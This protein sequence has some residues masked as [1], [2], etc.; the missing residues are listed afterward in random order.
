MRVLN[1]PSINSAL[2]R[3]I[4]RPIIGFLL[5]NQATYICQAATPQQIFKRDVIEDCNAAK[6]SL[7][8]MQETERIES[9]AYLTKVAG[10]RLKDESLRDQIA[11]L[12]IGSSGK[13]VVSG[14]NVGGSSI[15]AR[16]EIV[17]SL[18]PSR[19]ET[20]R[21][22][23]LELLTSLFPYSIEAIPDLLALLARDV[24][25]TNDSLF[26][27]KLR[28]TLQTLATGISDYPSSRISDSS[29]DRLLDHASKAE[30]PV[31]RRYA[32]SILKELQEAALPRLKQ[33]ISSSLLSTDLEVLVR[34]LVNIAQD[35]NPSRD[36]FQELLINEKTEVRLLALDTISSFSAA[37]WDLTWIQMIIARLGDFSPGVRSS[38]VNALSKV[39]AD[40]AN[41]ENRLEN[42]IK[43]DP[44]QME[45]LLNAFINADGADREKLT[46]SVK[47]LSKTFDD[48]YRERLL[49]RL[50][51]HI[52]S[53]TELSLDPSELSVLMEL[54][55]NSTRLS[56]LLEKVLL[57]S[58]SQ[59]RVLILKSM[60]SFPKL[61]A[62]LKRPIGKLIQQAKSSSATADQ[63]AAISDI[64]QSLPGDI[65][66]AKE[67]ISPE[68]ANE[69]L[70]LSPR[71]ISDT[72]LTEKI[73][74]L[75]QITGEKSTTDVVLK[76]LKIDRDQNR[77]LAITLAQHLAIYNRDILGAL[78][79]NLSKVDQ[80]SMTMQFAI[81][82][83]L[84]DPQIR[85]KVKKDNVRL[86]GFV[87]LPSIENSLPI[88]FSL[89]NLE[90]SFVKSSDVLL[91]GI[92]ALP[93]NQ[94]SR[95]VEI[96]TPNVDDVDLAIIEC[97]SDPSLMVQEDITGWILKYS[98]LDQQRRS[99][100]ISSLVSVKP[101]P[102]TLIH[103]LEKLGPLGISN[104]EAIPLWLS[105]LNNED[106]L[107]QLEALDRLYTHQEMISE[108]GDELKKLEARFSE[109][110][111]IIREIRLLL[112]LQSTDYK[113]ADNFLLEQFKEQDITWALDRLAKI[114][115]TVAVNVLENAFPELSIPN[116]IPTLQKIGDLSLME[117]KPRV[118]ARLDSSRGALR[119]VATVS[120]LK[121]APSHPKAI[122]L[123]ERELFGEF[124]EQL[125]TERFPQDLLAV[126][127]ELVESTRS[128]VVRH[129]G[130]RMIRHRAVD[131]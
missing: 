36:I 94:R 83:Y 107:A 33:K 86:K 114:P 66:A 84:G 39:I 1:I 96:I 53:S 30:S 125:V 103:I 111:S 24:E 16:D 35:P 73:L 72:L 58:K 129:N 15:I 122:S 123:L 3:I 29:W 26:P 40:L 4:L 80:I 19:E 52:I 89:L 116:E 65:R 27:V 118:E 7:P 38:A 18:D 113:T 130:E 47:L 55:G 101:H 68:T 82:R 117:L 25:V 5:I 95:L 71:V 87:R 6:Q 49:S 59:S 81:A 110:P 78:S 69:L 85:P 131:G 28:V 31:V 74:I 20:V 67:W 112:A 22:C 77:I 32:L 17:R 57:S 9:V 93:C 23:A 51:E 41:F 75:A 13:N 124:S 45:L 128:R 12:G 48:N 14:G 115:K 79:L 90:P 8:R 104:K 70:K 11:I 88:S 2:T 60:T 76:N 54:G 98:P 56:N 99:R 63:I 50:I 43:I 44:I 106:R 108:L 127:K 102:K 105:L 119:Y 34:L 37:N 42:P 46:S 62:T 10:F 21:G 61:A 121:I 100:L 109:V 64:I 120:L 126:L 91:T 92:K 97:I